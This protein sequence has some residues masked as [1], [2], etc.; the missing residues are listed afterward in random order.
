MAQCG[1]ACMTCCGPAL[2][3]MSSGHTNTLHGLHLRHTPGGL[4]NTI[5]YMQN[6]VMKRDATRDGDVTPVWPGVQDALQAGCEAR[7]FSREEER[8]ICGELSQFRTRLEH[9]L[10]SV[11]WC[12]AFL[13]HAK[14]HRIGVD[15]GAPPEATARSR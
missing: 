11:R 12:V 9:S 14:G 13:E 4:G 6:H 5:K 7:M 1:V 3:L 15:V 8:R 2:K 10:T